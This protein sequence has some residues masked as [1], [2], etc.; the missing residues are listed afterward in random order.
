MWPLALRHLFARPRQTLLTFLGI[1]FAGTSYI[2]ISSF[3]LGFREYLVDQLVN[4]DAQIRIQSREEFLS[5]ELLNKT[6]YNDPS[7]K[8]VYWH[9]PPSG[10]IDNARIIDPTGWYQR[11]EADP[12][13]VAY[14]PQFTA[15]VI[16]TRSS[17]SITGRLMGC[18]PA[19]QVRVTNI[20]DYMKEGS[21]SAIASGGNRV[22]LGEGLMQKLGT[23]MGEFIQVSSG[24]DFPKPFKVAGIFRTGIKTL[25][26]G[27]AFAS[28][29]DVQR[30]NLTPS[31]VSDIAVK[32]RDPLEARSIAE[33]WAK[34][35]QEKVQSW[36][37]INENF[38]NVFRIQDATRY[39]VTGV[40]LI[41]AGFG[42]YNI[43]NI[44]VT[45]KRRDIAILRSMGFEQRDVLLLFF[46]QGLILGLVGAF[47][48][49]VAG[50]AICS[51]LATVPF[52]GGPMGGSGFLNI[53]FNPKIYVLGW[54]LP[55]VVSVL[56]SL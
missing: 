56:A 37:Q 19:R 18:E 5:P 48:S 20:Q 24:R 22:I 55:V 16:M 25:D 8:F 30:I 39:F 36:D 21:F 41:V 45:Q 34:L 11:L 52:A 6:L 2:T 38:F 35:S 53:S 14:A 50:F 29:T 26:D 46:Y 49:L 12:R 32:I 10:R 4:N 15:Q 31:Q 44:V 43:L 9:S 27:T 3:F 47:V 42:I 40:I 51:Y 17:A 28:L 33:S 13:V 54:I 23:R 7:V 1:F